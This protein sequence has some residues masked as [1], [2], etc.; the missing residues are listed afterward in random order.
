MKPAAFVSALALTWLCAF[1]SAQ[2]Q[3]LSR[4]PDETDTAFAGRVLHIGADDD[5]HVTAAAWDGTPTLFADYLIHIAGE[6]NRL[7]V[8]LMRQPDGGYRQVQVTVGEVEGGTAHL[9]ALGLA[10][11]DHSGRQAL[12]T[13]LSWNV[14]HP[15]LVEGTDYEIR[16][17]APPRPGQTALTLMPISHRFAGGCECWHGAEAGRRQYHSH[18]RFQTIAAI[19]RELRRLGY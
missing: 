17:F 3:T 7:V 11:A 8:A 15:T 14:S 4:L 16:I 18:A 6:D 1:S 5:A 2:A 9:A 13:I 19:R 10:R 12:I